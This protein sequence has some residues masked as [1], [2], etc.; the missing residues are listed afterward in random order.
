MASSGMLR[1]VALVRSDVSEELIAPNVGVT[2]EDDKGTSR[3]SLGIYKST[4]LPAIPTPLCI[5]SL[6]CILTLPFSFGIS[7][8]RASVAS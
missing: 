6:D 5:L 3:C 7:P 2:R 4:P 1:R 8:Q